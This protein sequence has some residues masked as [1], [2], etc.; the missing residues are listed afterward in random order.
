MNVQ[1]LRVAMLALL[2]T[3]GGCG[4]GE[5]DEDTPTVDTGNAYDIEQ[6]DVSGT[7]NDLPGGRAP[8]NPQEANNPDGL[9]ENGAFWINWAVDDPTEPYD[10]SF[11]A[12][13]DGIIDG[14]DVRFANFS[15]DPANEPGRCRNSAVVSMFCDLSTEYI[16]ECDVGGG[17]FD[18]GNLQEDFDGGGSPVP[19]SILMRSCDPVNPGDCDAAGHPVSFE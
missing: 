7:N 19:A 15:C 5:A 8:I 4:G 17:N 2:V 1:S 6:F 14:D 18:S 13:L 16:L 10:V 3:L 11:Y 12:S 9:S